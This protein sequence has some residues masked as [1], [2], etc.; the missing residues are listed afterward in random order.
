[1]FG[2]QRFETHCKLLNYY[3]LNSGHNEQ[4]TNDYYYNNNILLWYYY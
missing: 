2:G 4:Y 1:M 3:V